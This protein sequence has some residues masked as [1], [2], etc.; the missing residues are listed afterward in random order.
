MVKISAGAGAALAGRRGSSGR[1]FSGAVPLGSRGVVH[2]VA[3]VL[4]CWRADRRRSGPVESTRR[5]P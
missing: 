2:P 1:G 4:P 5:M 3:G